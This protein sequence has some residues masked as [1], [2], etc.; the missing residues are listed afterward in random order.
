M[1]GCGS[2]SSR[3]EFGLR[4][5]VPVDRPSIPIALAP[6][7]GHLRVTVTA[8]TVGQRE[9]P[10]IAT[11]IGEALKTHEGKGK[12]FVLDL[13]SVNVLSSLGLGMCVDVRHRALERGMKP[14]LYGMPQH[15]VELLR[16]MKVD[17]LF[18][19]VHAAPDLDRL[20]AS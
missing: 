5:T 1:R 16:M 2:G 3:L 11:A 4:M 17:R 19:V 15:L 14:V 13:S 12:Y 20:L 6:Q 7:G 10:L 18:T 8:P 9:A